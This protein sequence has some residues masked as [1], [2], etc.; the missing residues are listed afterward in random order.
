MGLARVL[1][2]VWRG[3]VGRRARS[4]ALVL[5]LVVSCSAF[6]VLTGQSEAS[7]LAIRGTVDVNAR[8]AYDI[9]VRPAGS[10][11]ASE[12][13]SAEVQAGF[14]AG[15]RGGITTGQ[16][17][18]VLHLAGVEVAAPVANIGY[19]VPQVTI[20]V[21]TTKANAGSG[22]SVARVDARWSWDNGLSK[23]SAFPSFAYVTPNPLTIGGTD[24]ARY[25]AE[26]TATGA[27]LHVCRRDD[28]ADL[29][30]TIAT[31]S[32]QLYCYS[33]S[34]A[35]F[36]EDWA[37][38]FGLPKGHNGVAIDFP[39]PV[40]MMAIDPVQEAKLSGLDTAVTTGSYLKPGA[41]GVT[42]AAA[43]AGRTVPVLLSSSLANG[44]SL[45][46]TVS[47]LPASA[48]R[49]VA[50]GATGPDLARVTG[51]R[52]STARVE[53]G[54]VVRELLGS[55][56][57]SIGGRSYLSTSISFVWTVGPT[58]F[59][60]SS[61]QALS[62]SIVRNPPGAWS[63]INGDIGNTQIP[64]GG[65]DQAFRAQVGYHQDA[66]GSQSR[67][68]RPVI[69]RVGV[70]DPTKLAGFSSLSAVPL[71]TTAPTEV[72]GAA[73]TA[74][75]MLGGYPLEPATTIAGYQQPAPLIL[76]TLDA[77]Q[78]FDV[79][80]EWSLQG[81]TSDLATPVD[82]TAPISSIRVRVAGVTGVDALS[83]ERVR[84]VAQAVTDATG[85][86]VDVTIGASP[87][88]RTIA[89]PAGLRGRPA[90]ALSELWVK[91]GVAT[92]I[93]TAVDRKS[94][95]L[96]V[97]VLVVCGLFV[98]NTTAASVRARRGEL[99]VLS[100]LG[101]TPG[102]ILAL[103]LG[104][105]LLAGLA[106]GILG[107]LLAIG[108]GAATTVP[109]PL[110]RAALAI[111]AAVVVAL[112]AGAIPAWG[113]ARVAPMEAR[114]PVSCLPRRPHPSR[115]VFGLALVNV[116]RTP[117][118][119][120]VA[121]LGV[122]IAAA[123]FT[124]LVCLATAFRGA[125]TGT[126]LGDAISVQVRGADVAATISIVIIAAAGIGNL[127]YLNLRARATELATLTAL[128]WRP[129][130]IARLILIETGLVA[131]LFAITGAAL[132]LSLFAVFAGSLTGPMWVAAALAAVVGLV[133]SLLAALI[134]TTA[135][136][137]TPIAALLS[138]E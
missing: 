9:L 106:A 68:A 29:P 104:E 125:V 37:S 136:N 36:G 45:D 7:R 96:F 3:L 13:A 53:S 76:T 88:P 66:L 42:V 62:P 47:R 32:D 116:R 56:K 95:I 109:V 34:A 19:I 23:E 132:G 21:D 119:S 64:A 14:L 135:L 59:Q 6:A 105:L 130:V 16:W 17:Q 8:S 115:S 82:P 138:E 61:T 4:L 91:K 126:L 31:P 122:L 44:L 60:A 137:R 90:L 24:R 49:A 75:S 58:T 100:A 55:G 38:A 102:R 35:G 85:L 15:I 41:P 2:L 11:S 69:K 5:G 10:R 71:G 89:L 81:G 72:T 110:E 117:G 54:D 84:V 103:V 63:S 131:T 111:P 112:V 107:G 57:Q 118:R 87:T 77:V 51:T 86:D 39:V 30:L 101:W 114:R 22:R 134:P 65:D 73:P 74:W 108:V 33:R 127:T 121:G 12:D 99:G 83:R 48:A 27:Q 70:F 50:A 20:P 124:L 46:Y 128:G 98:A 123:A 94:A 93:V 25:D 26:T 113:A 78:A 18:Q 28:T 120:V 52:M 67:L 133:S 129:T 92:A 43:G 1:I 79:G 97:M 40:L 80:D